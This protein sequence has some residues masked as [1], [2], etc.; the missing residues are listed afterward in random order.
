[1]DGYQLTFYTE[2]N[3]RHEHH[4]VWEWLLHEAKHLGI[5]GATVINCAEGIGHAG[6]HH[7]AHM[8]K[9]ALKQRLLSA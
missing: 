5:H 7:A 1:M 9:L 6:A 3:R 8:L 2:Q 4:T